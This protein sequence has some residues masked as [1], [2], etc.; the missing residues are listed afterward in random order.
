MAIIIIF[1]CFYIIENFNYSINSNLRIGMDDNLKSKLNNFS[2]KK[3]S[4]NTEDEFKELLYL[5]DQYIS[6]SILDLNFP[7]NF[8]K[9]LLEIFEYRHDAPDELK[10]YYD[11]IIQNICYISVSFSQKEFLNNIL[12]LY[13]QNL[14]NENTR[15]KNNKKLS[16]ILKYIPFA[17]ST[18]ENEDLSLYNN[19]IMDLF[20]CASQSIKKNLNT[21]VWKMIAKIYTHE[22]R[23]EFIRSA[24]DYDLIDAVLQICLEN[25]IKYYPIVFTLKELAF[26]EKFIDRSPKDVKFD[27]LPLIGRCMSIFDI[28]KIKCLRLLSK[29]LQYITWDLSDQEKMSLEPFYNKAVIDIKT[30]GHDELPVLFTFLHHCVLRKLLPVYIIAKYFRTSAHA[31]KSIRFGTI[32]IVTCFFKENIDEA[33]RELNRILVNYKHDDLMLIIDSLPLIYQQMKDNYQLEFLGFINVVISAVP[34]NDMVAKKLFHAMSTLYPH[35]P[36]IKEYLHGLVQRFINTR[37]NILAQMISKVIELFGINYDISS[38]DWFNNVRNSLEICNNITLEFVFELI[39]FNLIDFN[40]IP[41]LFR[42][43]LSHRERIEQD[44]KIRSKVKCLIL[45]VAKSVSQTINTAIFESFDNSN[46][47]L[48]NS[49]FYEAYRNIDRPMSLTSFG[50]VVQTIIKVFSLTMTYLDYSEGEIIDI[51]RFCLIFCECMYDIVYTCLIETH[52]KYITLENRKR[53]KEE[54]KLQR[55]ALKKSIPKKYQMLLIKLNEYIDKEHHNENKRNSSSDMLQDNNNLKSYFSP[56]RNDSALEFCEGFQHES[57]FADLSSFFSEAASFPSKQVAT[58]DMASEVGEGGFLSLNVR[59][60]E[61][62]LREIVIEKGPKIFDSVNV[63]NL[64]SFLYYSNRRL[65]NIEEIDKFVLTSKR[66]RLILGFLCYSYVNNYKIDLKKWSSVVFQSKTKYDFYIASVYLMFA[67]K[68]LYFSR[69]P[70]RKPSYSVN[71]NLNNTQDTEDFVEEVPS[72]VKA[73]AMKCLIILNVN[74][75]YIL[76]HIP[77]SEPVR[78]CILSCIA[79]IVMMKIPEYN[80]EADKEKVM[81][82]LFQEKHSSIFPI[83]SLINCYIKPSGLI[84]SE[85][86][87]AYFPWPSYFYCYSQSFSYENEI[88]DQIRSYA[89]KYA[90]KNFKFA[91]Y[92]CILGL[93]HEELKQL[94]KYGPVKYVQKVYSPSDLLSNNSEENLSICSDKPPSFALAIFRSVS[95]TNTMISQNTISKLRNIF[96]PVHG[97]LVPAKSLSLLKYSYGTLPNDLQRGGYDIDQLPLLNETRLC[98]EAIKYVSYLVDKNVEC[99]TV[100]KMIMEKISSSDNYISCI[101]EVINILIENVDASDIACSVCTKKVLEGP[102]SLG[103]YLAFKLTKDVCKE[104]EDMYNAVLEENFIMSKERLELLKTDKKQMNIFGK[105]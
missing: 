102:N 58:F 34:N 95:I 84:L 48:D 35:I 85:D 56:S 97:G 24:N 64:E 88:P 43:L 50:R 90:S 104:F 4:N 92:L 13:N 44:Q 22:E 75:Y 27:I 39:E 77:Q 15:E 60:N 99:P 49:H 26:I 10:V 68:L 55:S 78:K 101:L 93:R 40:T 100:C 32:K 73:V 25:P 9:A 5:F 59:H 45:C 79:R 57:S 31:N 71:L 20:N 53:D 3:E 42:C 47:F 62:I 14:K 87:P 72:E 37:D 91:P 54:I 103:V 80:S 17:M 1:Y 65:E 11:K 66:Q 70:K 105:K 81:T 16:I 30:V 89:V 21:S 29:L 76:D 12:F 67:I 63:A 7:N 2:I 94:E 41:I 96:S 69:S 23:V 38:L 83:Y 8:Q 86:L 6:I 19:L 18:I 52:K 33:Q 61:F 51:I 28:K 36:K 74:K 82:C 98:S 46:C